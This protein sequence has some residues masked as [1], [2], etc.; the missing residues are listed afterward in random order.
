[1]I[2]RLKKLL[3]GADTNMPSESDEDVIQ[4]AVA[5]LL[6][7]IS[8][9]DHEQRPAEDEEIRRQLNNAF[10]L[11]DAQSEVLIKKAMESVDGSVSLFDFTRDLHTRMSYEKKQKVI[12]MLWRIALA[13]HDIDKYEDYMVGKIAELL[14]VARGDVIRLRHKVSEAMQ[15]ADN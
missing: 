15:L 12:E 3:G 1:M 14:Y 6:V 2:G 5:A 8:R 10:H 11:S 13:D 9:A 4:L 7:E